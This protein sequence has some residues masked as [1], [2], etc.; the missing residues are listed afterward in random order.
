[1]SKRGA[2][3]ISQ[4]EEDVISTVRHPIPRIEAPGPTLEF[5]VD[6]LCGRARASTLR[7]P[8]GDVQTP[9]FM[10]VG[11]QG[12]IKGFTNEKVQDI[13][14]K[15]ILANTYHIS[16][17]PTCEVLKKCDG[18]HNFMHWPGNLLTDSGGFQMV[19]LLKLAKITEE[20][21]EFED[22]HQPGSTMLLT[23]EKSIE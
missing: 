4:D 1:M 15:I 7:L 9:V 8:H 6:A 19:S 11:T 17:R 22:P 16:L 20:G 3:Q 23:P 10:P 2:D 12:T 14:C 18:L 13:G 21:V 5:T